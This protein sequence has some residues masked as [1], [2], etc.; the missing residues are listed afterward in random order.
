MKKQYQLIDFNFDTEC[1][2]GLGDLSYLLKNIIENTIPE[3][4]IRISEVYNE[5]E[6]K[7]IAT[8]AN[9]FHEMKIITDAHTDW[10]PDYFFVDL[11]NIPVVFETDKR[12]YCINPAIGLTGQDA[13]YFC[14]SEANLKEARARGIPLV[15]PGENITETKEYKELYGL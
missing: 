11:E 9:K 14:G 15:F 10:L 6:N 2:Y 7:F 3:F 12:Y 1:I 4:G 13:W 5:S 8:L